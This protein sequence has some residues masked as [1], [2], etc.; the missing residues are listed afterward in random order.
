[1]KRTVL[2]LIL[3]SSFS[4]MAQDYY[5][6]AVTKPRTGYFKLIQD[7]E[8]V[9]ILLPDGAD[10]KPWTR[11]INKKAPNT[12]YTGFSSNSK[13]TNGT[14]EDSDMSTDSF[15]LDNQ[16]RLSVVYNKSMWS[17]TGQPEKTKAKYVFTYNAANKL[18][19]LEYLK[20]VNPNSNNYMKSSVTNYTYDPNGKLILDSNINYFSNGSTTT[21]SHYA[22]TGDKLNMISQLVGA[23]TTA[24]VFYTWTGE[25][26]ESAAAMKFDDNTGE[27]TLV[28]CDTFYYNAQGQV[29]RH[30]RLGYIFKNGGIT[31]EPVGNDS[32][33]YTSDGQLLE[34]IARQWV[35]G[36][37]VNFTKT[38]ITY[39]AN[40][41]PIEGNEYVHLGS[42]WSAASRLQ[43]MFGVQTGLSTVANPLSEITIAPNPANDIITIDL[44]KHEADLRLFDITGKAVY[45][46]TR[47]N[48][49]HQIDLSPLNNGLYYASIQSEGFQRTVKIIVSH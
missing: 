11:E 4:L 18:E 36:D 35:D 43:Y 31:I 45:E 6:R 33:T 26:L 41:K 28:D 1:M 22:Y 25:L 39:D 48:G 29:T 47:V 23:D 27:W 10:W 15:V 17:Y 12:A 20:A 8:Y 14:W 21:I 42:D 5:P 30:W 34:E 2:L 38:I 40:N 3:F 44:D 46:Q 24:K 13:W 16:N 19:R 9:L 32:Y 7:N 37:W 49:K